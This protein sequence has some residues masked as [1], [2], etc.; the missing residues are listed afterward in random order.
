MAGEATSRFVW[1]QVRLA[2]DSP[3]VLLGVPDYFFRGHAGYA[4]A[5]QPRGVTAVA[6]RDY[7]HDIFSGPDDRHQ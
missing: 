1:S 5:C 3:A 6:A 4:P 2:V 7:Y